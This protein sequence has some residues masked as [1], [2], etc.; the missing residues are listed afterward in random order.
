[1]VGSHHSLNIFEVYRCN[2]KS[3]LWIKNDHNEIR[4]NNT[5]T[6]ILGWIK[7]HCFLEEQPKISLSGLL[8]GNSELHASSYKISISDIKTNGS[9]SSSKTVSDL[10]VTV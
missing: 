8:S 4:P 7:K 2:S 9:S 1:M 5:I 3:C 6:E 10:V